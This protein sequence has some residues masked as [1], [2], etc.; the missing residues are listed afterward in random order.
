MTDVAMAKWGKE[1]GGR[2]A[3]AHLVYVSCVDGNPKPTPKA[4]KISFPLQNGTV[5]CR[6][7]PSVSNIG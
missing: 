4:L 7:V 2:A 1:A 6:V 5:V 3:A